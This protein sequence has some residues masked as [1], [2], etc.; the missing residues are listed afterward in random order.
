MNEEHQ[1]DSLIQNIHSQLE[2]SVDEIDAAT[3]SRITRARYRALDQGGRQGT[4][5]FWVPTGAVAT[6]CVAVLMFLLVPN[7]PVEDPAPLDD[8]E[9]ISNIDD[10]ELLE[11]LEFYEWLEE[12]ELPT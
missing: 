2:S 9:L 11:D 1:H 5:N 12:H 6:A 7:T 10:L 8:F 3:Q 4:F